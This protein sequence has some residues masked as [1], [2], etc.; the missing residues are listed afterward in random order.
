MFAILIFSVQ[1]V[2]WVM[3]DINVVFLM[4]YKGNHLFET[5]GEQYKVSVRLS[6]TC[7]NAKEIAVRKGPCGANSLVLS[8]IRSKWGLFKKGAF[9]V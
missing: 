9:D 8:S 2:L 4:V 5:T 6:S 1:Q 3:E 7:V